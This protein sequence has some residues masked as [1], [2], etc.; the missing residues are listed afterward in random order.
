MAGDQKMADQVLLVDVRERGV[1]V[2]LTGLGE[3]P[4]TGVTME[5]ETE[6]ELISALQQ[7]I[8]DAGNPV[9]AGAVFGAPG[10]CLDGVIQLTHA[11]MRL[12]R[13]RLGAAL[14]AGRVVLVNDFQALALAMPLV[15]DSDLERIGGSPARGDASAAALGPGA[16]LGVSILNPDGFVGWTASAGEG[17]HVALAATSEREAAI[18]GVLR[19]WHGHVSAERVLSEV[20]LENI[21]K[22]LRHL[23]GLDDGSCDRNE[24]I[25]L[26]TAGD[27]LAVEVFEL[28]SG[29]LG[30]V[31]GD[32]A[33][34]AG[35]RSGVYIFSPLVVSLGSLFDRSLCRARF[36]A[37]GPMSGY[38]REIGL[39]LV[40][41]QNCGLLGLSTVL[42]QKALR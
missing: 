31:A 36:E 3:R 39:Y 14:G 19:D 38:L 37:K 42:E 9:L 18:I 40:T 35:A 17:G 15:L 41:A 10:P 16:G 34:T 8:A 33:L 12:D 29:W 25:R 11:N 20:G 24:L 26:A 6:E 21:A 27:R 13:E 4:G 2:A 1:V 22:A 23:E 30:A 7:I 32:L 28:F 5:C